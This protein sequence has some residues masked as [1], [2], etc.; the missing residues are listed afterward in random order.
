MLRKGELEPKGQVGVECARGRASSL[1]A[2]REILAPELLAGE[3]AAGGRAGGL[4]GDTPAEGLLLELGPCRWPV[5]RH[6][7]CTMDRTARPRDLARRGHF[8]TTVSYP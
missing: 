7:I 8:E 3:A 2:T 5:A 4:C 6:G 1:G